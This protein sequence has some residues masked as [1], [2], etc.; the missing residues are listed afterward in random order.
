MLPW[1][2]A[3][4]FPPPRLHSRNVSAVNASRFPACLFAARENLKK[5]YGIEAVTLRASK[6]AGSIG[7]EHGAMRTIEGV[8]R[9]VFN[10]MTQAS[11]LYFFFFL[12]Y[13]LF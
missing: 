2:C 13:L 12:C 10:P 6:T 5:R 11:T 4:T 3:G 7:I 8:F 1:P 9:G